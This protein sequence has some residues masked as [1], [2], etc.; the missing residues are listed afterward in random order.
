MRFLGDQIK[1]DEMDMTCITHWEIRK[2]HTSFVRILK[3][4][5]IAGRIILKWILEI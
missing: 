1:D 5:T 4:G 2:A 3:R